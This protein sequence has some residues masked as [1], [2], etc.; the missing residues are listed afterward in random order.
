MCLP[1]C[2]TPPTRMSRERQLIIRCTGA[3]CTGGMWYGL[4]LRR[5][6]HSPRGWPWPL[7][8]GASQLALS[9]VSTWASAQPARARRATDPQ[10]G[11][12]PPDRQSTPHMWCHAATPHPQSLCA[13]ALIGKL[14]AARNGAHVVHVEHIKTSSGLLL[15]ACTSA[16]R[17]LPMQRPGRGGT[18]PLR[19]PPHAT[20]PHCAGCRSTPTP[21]DG[22]AARSLGSSPYTAHAPHVGHTA[23]LRASH[24]DPT[25]CLEASYRRGL[26]CWWMFVDVVP[27][28]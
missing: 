22:T 26:I 15:P 10:T 21:K 1:G 16:G 4:W 6:L 19:T 23:C 8:V 13:L 28:P 17:Y 11:L 9:P 12:V 2:G 14:Q 18:R 3:T 24:T 5:H 20:A 7:A 27:A 25:R